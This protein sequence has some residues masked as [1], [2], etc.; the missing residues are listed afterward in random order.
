MEIIDIQQIKQGVS[1]K[2]EITFAGEDADEC[3]KIIMSKEDMW[4][5]AHYCFDE[6]SYGAQLKKKKK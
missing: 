1:E 3:A 2:F 6:L 5:I 4:Q